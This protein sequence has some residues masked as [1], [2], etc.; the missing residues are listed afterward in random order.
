MMRNLTLCCSVALAA[1]LLAGCNDA[2][3]PNVA[4]TLG[5][6]SFITETDVAVM[7][8]LL[9][10]DANG[11]AL[12]FSVTGAPE[13]GN[14]S[15]MANGSF[16][17]TPKAE[18]TGTDRFMVAVTDGE[19]TTTGMVTVDVAVAVVSFLSY[20]RTAYAQPA[21]AAPLAVNGREFTQDATSTA[22]YA[23]LLTGPQ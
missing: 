18:F 10:S 9:A 23:D 15:V 21:D 20:S 14:V 8:K 3:M 13:H 16:T 17:Y 12:T 5:S 1:A 6:N 2:D 22:D 7:D 11:D 4:P 19:L